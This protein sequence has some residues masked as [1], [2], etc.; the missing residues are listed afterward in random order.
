MLMPLILSATAAC[1]SNYL[2]GRKPW[3]SATFCWL[4]RTVIGV[5][6]GALLFN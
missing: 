4:T 3:T 1:I 2:T 6:I 5:L